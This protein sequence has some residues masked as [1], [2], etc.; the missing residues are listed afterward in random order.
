MHVCA[1]SRYI[2]IVY[3]W[4]VYLYSPTIRSFNVPLFFH[5]PW[6]KM[7]QDVEQATQMLKEAAKLDP[8]SL[9]RICF[10]RES[11]RTPKSYRSIP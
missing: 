4:Y 5:L 2:N 9:V 11:G 3:I 1:L 8:T 6:S 7:C 10:V